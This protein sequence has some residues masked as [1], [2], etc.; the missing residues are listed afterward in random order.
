MG[1]FRKSKGNLP[2]HAVPSE[3][4]Y[5]ATNGM[6][7]PK[8]TEGSMNKSEES[9]KKSK[10]SMKKSGGFMNKIKSK[11]KKMYPKKPSPT[12]TSGGATGTGDSIGTA[13]GTGNAT[14]ASTGKNGISH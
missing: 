10:G 3:H 2:A 12:S 11:F 7:T 1:I 14:M 5:N 9:M 13:I 8:E 6:T 4:G